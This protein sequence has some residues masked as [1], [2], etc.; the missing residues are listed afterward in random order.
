MCAAND[1]LLFFLGREFEIQGI[2]MKSLTSL[3]FYTNVVLKVVILYVRLNLVLEA[4]YN[5]RSRVQDFGN[6]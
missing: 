5:F 4:L 6:Q 2:Y 1:H 3:V